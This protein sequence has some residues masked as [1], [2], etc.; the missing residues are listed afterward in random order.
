MTLKHYDE[1]TAM[2]E[3]W[4]LSARDDGRYQIQRYDDCTA[5]SD[6]LRGD[7]LPPFTSD[8]EAAA[9]VVDMAM[10]GSM[11]HVEALAMEGRRVQ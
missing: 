6:S 9:Y 5:R 3:G 7:G 2:S 1:Q 11:L 4:L 8:D 10:A